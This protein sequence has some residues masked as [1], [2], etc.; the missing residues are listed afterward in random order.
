[1]IDAHLHSWQLG[2]HG[3]VWPTPDLPIIYR[4]FSVADVRG[5]AQSLGVTG[6]IL[7]QTQTSD[8]DT[9]YLLA[10][11]NSDAFVVAV[12][13]WV[14]L[15]APTAT[16][17]I[18]H[19]AQYPKMRGLRPMLQALNEDDWL[20]RPELAPAI[21]AMCAQNLSF[22]A[23]VYPRHLTYLYRFAQRYPD[24]SI[25]INHGAKPPIAN[26]DSAQ[27]RE[28]LEG[29]TALAKLPSVFCKLSGLV[30]EANAEQGDPIINK[31]ISTLLRLFGPERLVW[32]SDW[33]VLKLAANPEFASYQHW[34]TMSQD[35]LALLSES[36]RQ[37]IFYRNALNF[38]R[39]NE[40]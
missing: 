1:M 35:S 10:C 36:E 8:A 15:A 11:A 40:C 31:Y 6:S 2:A 7:V 32:G 9:D 16:A 19:L 23:L 18:A 12:I 21:T 38:Y 27:E 20:L 29:L 24:L 13:G 14:D 4:D 30:T 37:A 28:W 3:C 17:R 34:L 5:L 25:M 39:L 26:A 33:P 22:E